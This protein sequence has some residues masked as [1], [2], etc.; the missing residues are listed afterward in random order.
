MCFLF[1]F[2]VVLFLESF[3]HEQNKLSKGK[4]ITLNMFELVMYFDCFS[5]DCHSHGLYI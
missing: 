3:P 4:L 1:C 2:D 5:G